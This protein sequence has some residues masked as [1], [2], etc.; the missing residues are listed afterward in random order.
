MSAD[1]PTRFGEQRYISCVPGSP[2]SPSG[3]LLGRDD[4]RVGSQ[5]EPAQGVAGPYVCQPGAKGGVLLG[6]GR[7]GIPSL[8]VTRQKL[9]S[10]LGWDVGRTVLLFPFSRVACRATYRYK[11]YYQYA[12][13]PRIRNIVAFLT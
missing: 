2:P 8:K 7:R 12:D 13:I 3:D 1:G 10:F 4:P 11:G 5:G 9:F 6:W